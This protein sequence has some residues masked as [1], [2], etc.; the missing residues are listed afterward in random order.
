M[1]IFSKKLLVSGIS[2]LFVFVSLFLITPR[3]VLAETEGEACSNPGQWAWQCTSNGGSCGGN[4][5]IGYNLRCDDGVWVDQS[6]GS[7]VCTTECGTCTGAPTSPPAPASCPS[8][9]TPRPQSDVGQRVSDQ[10]IWQGSQ[11]GYMYWST[12]GIGWTVLN[13]GKVCTTQQFGPWN[14]QSACIAATPTRPV[15]ATPTRPA[16]ATS[17]P[18]PAGG[19]C[20][21]SWE[22]PSN[23]AASSDITVKVKGVSGSTW[24]NVWM[25]VDGASKTLK[26]IESGPTFVYENIN[27]GAVG[28]T[29]SL[30][31]GTNNGSVTCGNASFTTGGGTLTPS[32]A[33]TTAT[34]PTA[35]PT[36]TP[37]SVTTHFRV[38][39]SRFGRGDEGVN[40]PQWMEF[41][42]EDGGDPVTISYKFANAK[43][44][45]ELTLFV[46]YKNDKEKTEVYPKTI[47][48]IGPN[49]VI[50]SASC[51]YDPSGE[52]TL[53]TLI[54]SN[55]G[56]HDEQGAGGVKINGQQADIISWVPE[57]P[58]PTV[59]PSP[60]PTPVVC[61]GIAGK[62]CPTGFKCEIPDKT[63]PDASGIC[64]PEK[65]K[66]DDKV[67][68][69]V[70][71]SA[72]NPDGTQCKDFPTP[73]DVSSGWVKVASCSG[74]GSGT[75]LGGEASQSR[76]IAK[77]KDKM[78]G[79]VRIPLLL[80]LDDGRVALTSSNGTPTC[81]VNTTTVQFAAKVGCRSSGNFSLSDVNVNITELV[82]G[83]K[84]SVKQKL[85]LDKDGNLP[86]DFIP[87]LEK[88]KKYKL[89]VKA[90]KTV[91]RKI[92]FTPAEGSNILSE[93]SLPIGDIAPAGNPDGKIN[94][95]DRSQI[96]REWS[97]ANDTAKA[98]DLNLDGRVNSLDWSCMRE[99]FNKE[100]EDKIQ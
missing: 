4:Q 70:I 25:K 61:G 68:A 71:T 78:P 24:Q 80:T 8:G 53:V 49:P 19:T 98:G 21:V 27:T 40:A 47:K 33:P 83:A 60:T 29:H 91:A 55:F 88:G 59:E 96:V 86:S 46:Q 90:P 42:D 52:G 44:G 13:D 10:V 16:G 36:P 74:V 35:T 32:V 95:S 58:V 76:V 38:S 12:T 77:I 45:D 18:T 14:P 17:T 57:E 75:V 28:S 99:N 31:F 87:L 100:D 89:V 34:T 7:G 22:I 1:S 94:V 9:Q 62:T 79:K 20:V 23:P 39:E 48:Y 66:N 64:V 50:T 63:I 43:T 56:G 97:S 65:D 51:S 85:S 81:T 73:C 84:P 82:S 69:Q 6:Y 72:K 30:A 15:G 26:T 92:E 2:L 11:C 41:K 37:P 67:C 3:S 93:V 5:C 54:G